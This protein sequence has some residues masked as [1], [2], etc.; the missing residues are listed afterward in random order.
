MSGRRAN[1]ARDAQPQQARQA[2]ECSLQLRKQ[3]PSADV[4]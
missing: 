2:L 3:T 4:G 1:F